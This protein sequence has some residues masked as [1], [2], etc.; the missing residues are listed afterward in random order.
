MT[1]VV[2]NVPAEVCE[3]CGEAYVDE[4]TAKDL[5]WRA[6]EAVQA[7]VVLDIREYVCTAGRK[8]VGER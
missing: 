2:V 1:L 7:G 5:L 6:E 3:I 8:E 4:A